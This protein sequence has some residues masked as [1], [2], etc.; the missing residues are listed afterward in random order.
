VPRWQTLVG[1]TFATGAAIAT[2]D[3]WYLSDEGGPY[4]GIAERLLIT[5]A[6]VWVIVVGLRLVARRSTRDTVA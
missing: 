6:A 4:A 5:A 2:F 3:A 1:F